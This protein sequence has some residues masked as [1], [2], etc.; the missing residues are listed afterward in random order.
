MSITSDKTEVVKAEGKPT[1]G[2]PIVKDV[3]TVSSGDYTPKFI[4]KACILTGG[5]TLKY[6]LRLDDTADA[7][8]FEAEGRSI[9]IGDVISAIETGT[10]AT[11]VT[12]L[13]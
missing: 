10:T 7:V 13:G 5:T 3:W 11:S 12:W 1:T 4:I 9:V 2:G 8:V 6:K